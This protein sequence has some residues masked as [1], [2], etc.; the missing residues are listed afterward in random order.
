MAT[1]L[2]FGPQ[3]WTP[4]QGQVLPL[5][6]TDWEPGLALAAGP[7]RAHPGRAHPGRARPG[8]VA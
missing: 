8:G 2:D 1:E 3:G 4:E 5:Q 6:A 7:Y